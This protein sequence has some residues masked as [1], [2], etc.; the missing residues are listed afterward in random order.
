MTTNDPQSAL[1]RWGLHMGQPAVVVTL[2]GLSAILA[3]IGPF[4]TDRVL[5]LV[6]R[7]GYWAVLVAA[8][9]V[10]GY[11]ASAVLNPVLPRRGAVI[12]IGL[13]IGLV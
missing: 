4:E 3:L 13:V 1:R 7:F 5:G 11:W 2:A 9:Y 8:S 10:I 6:P 12:W